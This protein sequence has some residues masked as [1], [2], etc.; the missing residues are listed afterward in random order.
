MTGHGRSR[1]ATTSTNVLESTHDGT[2]AKRARLEL[3]EVASPID[4]RPAS[5][6][7]PEDISQ[8]ALVFYRRSIEASRAKDFTRAL[9]HA[10][11][12]LLLCPDKPL[13]LAGA[14]RGFHD[15]GYGDK[16]AQA[17][18][19][20]REI[21]EAMKSPPE[22][23]VRAIDSAWRLIFPFDGFPNE[24]VS[25]IFGH[26]YNS[27][28]PLEN[29]FIAVQ[30]C[31]SWRKLALRQSSLW[32]DTTIFL[33]LPEVN[34]EARY[35]H[36]YS[37]CEEGRLYFPAVVRLCGE[38]SMHSLR[39]IKMPAQGCLREVEET[40]KLA[41]TSRATLVNFEL[42][43]SLYTDCWCCDRSRPGFS[44]IKGYTHEITTRQLEVVAAAPLLDKIS[45][46]LYGE[47]D[48]ELL[49]TLGRQIQ[50]RAKLP[51]IIRLV[52]TDSPAWDDFGKML[53]P[54]LRVATTLAIEAK[55]VKT[56]VRGT[57]TYWK[58]AACCSQTVQKLELP[59]LLP[60]GESSNLLEGALDAN[61]RFPF[62]TDLVLKSHEQPRTLIPIPSPAKP[63]LLP[64]LR[65]LETDARALATFE[66][67]LLRTA[68]LRVLFPE[69]I[70]TLTNSLRCWEH[71]ECLM[72]DIQELSTEGVDLIRTA[73]DVVFGLLAYPGFGI[74]VCPNLSRIELACHEVLYR[75]STP[76]P[77]A[78]SW[79]NYSREQWEA[80]PHLG[81]SIFRLEQGRRKNCQDFNDS[82]TAQAKYAQSSGAFQRGSQRSQEQAPAPDPSIY[83]P[84]AV[85]IDEIVLEGWYVDPDLWSAVKA[86]ATCKITCLPDPSVMEKK[87][88][89][90]P[91]KPAKG[92]KR[93]YAW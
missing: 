56:A 21:L 6:C 43:S 80:L 1:L 68:R 64:A 89:S 27:S 5:P 74:P 50:G 8:L 93:I 63:F 58:A 34:V 10:R 88:Y 79:Q 23:E 13:Y 28:T 57:V 33:P 47:V 25:E 65:T 60:S 82:Q 9:R 73:V 62:L 69:D 92:E 37:A 61:S 78:R 14:A 81:S 70:R 90:A 84:H 72:I 75:R 32:R 31:S 19:S 3:G 26:L 55:G 16:A 91:R 30:I 66:T 18:R 22:E 45:L 59:L 87:L 7:S 20:A 17:L 49:H 44:D 36:H 11:K 40:V 15:S 38:R 67:P 46:Q 71:L 2:E 41:W 24:L 12:C 51:S 29:P 48:K 39:T 52:M 86:T 83:F 4:G 76:D 42:H 35:E 77:Y 54:L 53:E 85:P